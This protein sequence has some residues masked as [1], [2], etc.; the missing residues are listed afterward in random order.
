MVKSVLK[1][2]FI[3]LLL[4]IAIV[5]IL[6]VIFYNYIPTNKTIPNKLAEYTTPENVKAEIDEKLSETEKQEISYQIDGADLKLYRQSHAY[7]TGKTNPFS[8]STKVDENTENTGNTGNTEN[9]TNKGNT[10]DNGMTVD[11][12]STDTFYKDE[13]T[14]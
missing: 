8:A 12:K 6:G 9:T 13:G 4:C 1:E 14:K 3:M 11:P 7:T 5:L 2:I 10:V